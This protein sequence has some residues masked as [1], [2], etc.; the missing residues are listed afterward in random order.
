M[1]WEKEG[2]PDRWERT[3]KSGVFVIVKGSTENVWSTS[4]SV[5][6]MKSLR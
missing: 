4:V 1:D 3:L 6:L 2:F 5:F